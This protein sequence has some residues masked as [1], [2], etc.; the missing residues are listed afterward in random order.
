MGEHNEIFQSYHVY[1]SYCTINSYCIRCPY[2]A[3]K[4][5]IEDIEERRVNIVNMSTKFMIVLCLALG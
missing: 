5:H 3:L 4:I 1:S 2:S